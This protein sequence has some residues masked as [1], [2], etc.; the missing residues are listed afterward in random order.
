MNTAA[1]T[2]LVLG[3]FLNTL[4]ALGV[5]N[6]IL[7]VVGWVLILIAVLIYAFAGSGLDLHSRL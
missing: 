1:L 3:V 6:A 7:R 2:C 5:P 4:S